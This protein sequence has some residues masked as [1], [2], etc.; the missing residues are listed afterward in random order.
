M[1]WAV[2]P[3]YCIARP[4]RLKHFFDLQVEPKHERVKTA[5]DHRPKGWAV[6]LTRQAGSEQRLRNMLMNDQPLPASL[7]PHDGVAG[8]EI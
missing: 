1:T 6:A 3:G 8:I 4:W 5:I 7:F 2:G